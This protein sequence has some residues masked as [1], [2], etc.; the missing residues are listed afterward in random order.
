MKSKK[1]L[2]DDITNQ[3]KRLEALTNKVDYKS[4]YEEIFDKLVQEKFDEI[5]ELCDEIAIMI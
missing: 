1:K 2:L 5:K 4:I 3:N